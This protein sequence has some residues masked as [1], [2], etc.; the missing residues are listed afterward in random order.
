MKLL[1]S[2]W[3]IFIPLTAHLFCKHI[4]GLEIMEFED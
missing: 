2:F 3:Y 4:C 1:E